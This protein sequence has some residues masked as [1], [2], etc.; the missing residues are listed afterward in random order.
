MNIVTP[1]VNLK[2]SF[3]KDKRWETTVF[4]INPMKADIS[5]PKTLKWDDIQVPEVWTLLNE[6][7]KRVQ[8]SDNQLQDV[9]ENSDG[10]VIIR[11]GNSRSIHLN[12]DDKPRRSTSIP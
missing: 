10:S 7:P 2:N 8:G 5:V 3:I 11:V 6:V 4:Q 1:D 12:T 9:I